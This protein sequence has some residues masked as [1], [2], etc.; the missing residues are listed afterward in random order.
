MV[1]VVFVAASLV[2]FVT[3]IMFGS[4]CFQISYGFSFTSLSSNLPSLAISEGAKRHKG[5][6]AQPSKGVHYCSLSTEDHELKLIW[7]NA[8]VA[9]I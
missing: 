3:V 1:G 9:F 6:D 8:V 5:Y 2:P 4:C 7:F